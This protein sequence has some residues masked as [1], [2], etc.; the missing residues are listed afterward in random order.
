MLQKI[1]LKIVKGKYQSYRKL[2]DSG[3]DEKSSHER[4]DSSGAV[5]YPGSGEVLVSH[6]RAGRVPTHPNHIS[7][8]ARPAS[9]T[10]ASVPEFQVQIFF[11]N[12]C[13]MITGPS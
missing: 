2:P 12:I 5:D 9:V 1:N 6:G 10:W 7:R 4:G 3:S 8:S 11:K 13:Q